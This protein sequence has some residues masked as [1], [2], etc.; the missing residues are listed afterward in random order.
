LRAFR[1]EMSILDNI[2]NPLREG[3]EGEIFTRQARPKRP[4]MGD[5]TSRSPSH[6][7]QRSLTQQCI[8]TVGS[9]SCH[10]HA[11]HRCR[12][13]SH[14]FGFRELHLVHFLTSVSMRD[15]LASEHGREV[16]S[17][18]LEHFLNRCKKALRRNMA[19]RYSTT[20]LNIT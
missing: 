7:C 16:L 5:G 10:L 19:V 8:L 3:W 6:L 11:Q 14:T 9:K 15:G 17:H 13:R 2:L 18:T 12:N 4:E 1:F 20:H